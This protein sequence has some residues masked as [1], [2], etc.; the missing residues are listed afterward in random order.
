[1]AVLSRHDCD[2]NVQEMAKRGGPMWS[3]GRQLFCRAQPGGFVTLAFSN[4]RLGRFRLR[5]LATAAP[6]F[7]V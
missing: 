3:A 5:V 6:D 4:R 2:V 7:G 1:M